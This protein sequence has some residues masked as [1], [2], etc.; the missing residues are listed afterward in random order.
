MDGSTLSLS[1]HTLDLSQLKPC[2]V[3]LRPLGS[4]R[5]D[6]KS[7]AYDALLRALEHVRLER[8]PRRGWSVVDCARAWR[9]AIGNLLW[10]GVC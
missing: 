1:W 8:A 6:F 2:K 3:F 9:C 4:K 10:S 5:K 7:S